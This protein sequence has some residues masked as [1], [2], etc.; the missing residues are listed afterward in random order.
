[1]K[2]AKVVLTISMVVFLCATAISAAAAERI[3]KKGYRYTVYNTTAKC[4]MVCKGEKPI[5]AYLEDGL[6]YALDLPLAI[7][8]PI[9]CPIVAPV[10]DRLDPVEARTYRGARY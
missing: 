5:L 6:A 1:M 9:T 4:Q 8:S 7:L 2:Y 3:T 10:L